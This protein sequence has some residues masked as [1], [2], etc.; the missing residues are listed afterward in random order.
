MKHLIPIA[1][2]LMGCMPPINHVNMPEPKTWVCTPRGVA[3]ETGVQV[4]FV[5]VWAD[6]IEFL[7]ETVDGEIAYYDGMCV[8]TP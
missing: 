4:R 3:A 5:A 7:F 6:K 1:V 8:A 2:C